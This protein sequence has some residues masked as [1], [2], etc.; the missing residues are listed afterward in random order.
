AVRQH[1]RD[2]GGDVGLQ[3]FL[4]VDAALSFAGRGGVGGQDAAG[5]YLVGLGD[6]LG[7]DE[8]GDA[9]IFLAAAAARGVVLDIG[10]VGDVDGHGQEGADLV[11][12][13]V[14][15][16]GTAAVAPQRVRVVGGDFRL[17]HRH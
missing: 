11:G 14:L 4:A 2:D 13:L 8:V 9:R 6:G 16:E 10:L 5:Q 15:E 17:R 1:L 7:T 3:G 12:A